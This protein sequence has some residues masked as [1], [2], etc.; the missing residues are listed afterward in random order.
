MPKT[1]PLACWWCEAPAIGWVRS[2]TG[3]TALLTCGANHVSLYPQPLPEGFTGIP[4]PPTLDELRAEVVR[5]AVEYR[6]GCDSGWSLSGDLLGVRSG[7]LNSVRD[8]VT[9]P[10][11]REES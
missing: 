7:L 1:I 8:M 11:Y 9:H 2:P 3:I 5:W 10:D 4:A 6:T